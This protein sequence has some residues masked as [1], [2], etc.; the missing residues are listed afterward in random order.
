MRLDQNFSWGLRQEGST[1]LE[2]VFSSEPRKTAPQMRA[3]KCPWF[4]LLSFKS[5]TS[6]MCLAPINSH[7]GW[8]LAYARAT[9]K[10]NSTST[11][12][13]S[14]SVTTR[15]TSPVSLLGH[16]LKCCTI[17]YGMTSVRH[18]LR[19][20]ASRIW[21][22]EKVPLDTHQAW[23][24]G[25]GWHHDTGEPWNGSDWSGARW[26]GSWGIYGWGLSKGKA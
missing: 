11:A 9:Q 14:K 3:K 22:M 12:P 2:F 8:W 21:L 24:N 10:Q 13:Q 16:G 1:S 25:D 20:S 6:A 5:L 15:S 19:A 17:L 26:E 7:P 18:D 23:K 4:C